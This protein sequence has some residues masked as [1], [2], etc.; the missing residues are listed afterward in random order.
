MSA[1]A[2]LPKMAMSQMT[3]SIRSDFCIWS[4]IRDVT[5]TEVGFSKNFLV[6]RNTNFF[7]VNHMPDSVQNGKETTVECRFVSQN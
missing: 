2:R 3:F 5:L 4:A 1:L 6:C 7:I